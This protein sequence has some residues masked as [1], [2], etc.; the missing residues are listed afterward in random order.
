MMIAGLEELL[1]VATKIQNLLTAHGWQFCF[2]GG[3]AV[4][5]WGDPRFTRDVDLTLLTGFGQEES[6]VD[7]LLKELRPRRPNSREFAVTSRVLLATTAEGV[8]VDIALGALPFEERTIMRA[9]LWQLRDDISLRTCSAEDLVT[10]KVF[11][12][13]HLDWGD[14]ERVL[15]RQHGKLNLAQIRSELKPLLELKGELD[16]LETLERMLATVERRLRAK[17]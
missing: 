7:A 14:V 1:L 10:H 12:G 4:Q 3:V 9:S 2:I 11:A 5:R 6:F 16:G 13:R 8:D 17:P 15:T